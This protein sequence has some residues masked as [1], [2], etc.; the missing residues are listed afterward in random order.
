[1]AYIFKL[2]PFNAIKNSGI[3]AVSSQVILTSHYFKWFLKHRHTKFHT[4]A[5][6]E[7]SAA[8][9]FSFKYKAHRHVY[10]HH[11]D[12]DSFGSS[13]ALTASSPPGFFHM[14]A[15]LH[16]DVFRLELGSPG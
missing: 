8:L 1:M 13:A 3:G 2:D 5:R 15:R 9:P 7:W 14:Y 10:V 12:G 16:N 6:P 11:D 4:L